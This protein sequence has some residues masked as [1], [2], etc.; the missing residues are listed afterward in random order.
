M[1]LHRWYNNIREEIYAKKKL[2]L[3]IVK[4]YKERLDDA[5]LKWK[6]FQHYSSQIEDHRVILFI[7]NIEIREIGVGQQIAK[8]ANLM[9]LVNL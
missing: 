2:S 6:R 3:I 7:L 5:F 8:I 9:L 4:G 1:Y